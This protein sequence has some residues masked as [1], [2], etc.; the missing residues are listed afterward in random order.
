[1]PYEPD[2]IIGSQKRSSTK[3]EQ[4][5]MSGTLVAVL[6]FGITL[7][8]IC[9][10]LLV[11]FC[12]LKRRMANEE[13]LANRNRQTDYTEVEPISL[14][15]IQLEQK[16]KEGSIS[17]AEIQ[18]LQQHRSNKLPVKKLNLSA[19]SGRTNEARTDG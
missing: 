14:D 10:L 12:W 16:L 1:M 7:T 19:V 5:E 2:D 18:A 17:G 6:I 8:M 13:R 11:C 15:M 4:F 3:D 9:G